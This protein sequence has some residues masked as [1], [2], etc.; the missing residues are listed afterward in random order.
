[1][2]PALKKILEDPSNPEWRALRPYWK[3]T[4]ENSLDKPYE[5]PDSQAT[6]EAAKQ[7]NPSLFSSEKKEEKMVNKLAKL[8]A[9]LEADEKSEKDNHW[10]IIR[11]LAT[12]RG[13]LEGPKPCK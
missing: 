11:R 9:K 10:R 5:K 8:V 1:M 6:L 3:Y 4:S 12:L 7:G 13:R 2:A